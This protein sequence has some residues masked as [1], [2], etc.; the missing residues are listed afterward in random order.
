[1][2]TFVSVIYASQD[3]VY[4]HELLNHLQA[5]PLQLWFQDR[6]LPGQDKV[7]QRDEHLGRAQIIVLL[8]S[9]HLHRNHQGDI[10]VAMQQAR[11]GA[12]VMPILLRPV[13][14]QG[15]P[16]QSLQ[17][18]PR[19]G[20]AVT[21]LSRR[22]RAWVEIAKEIQRAVDLSAPSPRPLSAP[23]PRPL[24]A[25]ALAA[26]PQRR[27]ASFSPGLAPTHASRFFGRRRE[28]HQLLCQWR[29]QPLQSSAI[30]GADASGK[31]SLLRHLSRIAATP[32][33]EL[34]PEQREDRSLRGAVKDCLFISVDFQDP[35]CRTARGF[36]RKVL[37]Q[38]A[39][40]ESALP[41]IDLGDFVERA[42]SYLRRP[43]V[44]LL[45]EVDLAHELDSDL[46]DCLRYL[47]GSH[48]DGNLAFVLA[49]QRYESLMTHHGRGSPFH[50]LIGHTIEL[51]PLDPVDAAA[52]INSAPTPFSAEDGAWILEQSRCWPAALQHLCRLRQL[53]L[54]TDP[55]DPS[56]RVEA[57]RQLK[58]FQH[59]WGGQP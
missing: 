30:L 52:L 59:L 33:E 58:R 36:C 28:V 39:P 10:D 21:E 6:V 17:M 44:I 4:L 51:G 40:E 56:W 7:A 41:C 19:C 2:A 23:S 34:R 12:C 31:T 13:T 38:L 54:E 1:M 48:A 15:A 43:T 5:L 42:A 25:P 20:Q 55:R 45:D 8:L 53:A 32:E 57:Q 29:E 9:A 46:W 24:G 49:A 26:P 37:S 14:I 47:T 18:F 27:P 11:R 35:G 50:N 16:Y 22:E 3:R